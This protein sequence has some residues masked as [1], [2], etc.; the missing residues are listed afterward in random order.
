M[1]VI[2]KPEHVGTEHP[3]YGK[4][5][6]HQIYEVPELNELWEPAPPG[7]DTPAPKP[8]KGGKE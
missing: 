2:P 3:T 5:T 1:K 8:H 4:L 7:E 6:R